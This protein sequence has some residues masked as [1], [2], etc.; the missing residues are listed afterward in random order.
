MVKRDRP[1]PGAVL[2]RVAASHLRAGAFDFFAAREEPSRIRQL[3]D[4]AIRRHDLALVD[5]P[6]DI[7]SG[8]A[9]WWTVKLSSS[10]VGCMRGSFMVS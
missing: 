6:T 9:L 5:R 7:L 10:L 4:Y 1:L 2:T 8:C 3:T